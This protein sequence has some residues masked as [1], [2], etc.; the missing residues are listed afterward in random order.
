MKVFFNELLF[1]LMLSSMVTLVYGIRWHMKPNT[2]KCL[3]EELRQNVLVKGEYEVAPVEG[4][5]IDYIVRDS[6]NHI[7][8]QKED[9][10]TGKFTFSVENY[11][12]FEICFISKVTGNHRGFVQEV[13]LDIKTGVEAKNYEGIAEASKLKPLELD[14]KRLEDMSQSIVLDFEDMKKRADEMRNTNE[15]TNKRVFYFGMLSMI[16]LIGFAT[17]QIFYLKRYFKAKRLIE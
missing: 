17:W 6:K 10:T 16:C 13:Y 15:S 11:D 14:L 4:Q 8:S 12:M 9:I 3:K 1:T 5:K 2:E 7:L